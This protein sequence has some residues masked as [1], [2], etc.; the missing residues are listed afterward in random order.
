MSPVAQ[1]EPS[2]VF[3]PA[4][5]DAP[6]PAR[7]SRWRTALLIVLLLAV[8][9][10]SAWRF[11]VRWPSQLSPPVPLTIPPRSVVVAPSESISAAIQRVASGGEVIVEP[12]VYRETLRL[13]SNVR[14]RSRIARAASVRLSGGASE[15]DAA[16]VAAE[17]EGAEVS[18]LQI[19]GDSATPLGVGVFVRNATVL[20]SDLEI[21]GAH[22][23]A[24]EIAAGSGATVLG[25]YVHDNPGAGLTV[26]ATAAPRIA[27]SQFIRNGM[28]ERAAGAI[29]IDAGARPHLDRNVFHGV[30]AE[31]LTGLTQAERAAARATNWF[32]PPDE[33]SGRRSGGSGARGRR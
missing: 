17:V 4:A 22:V 9:A 10:Y 24:I 6:A 3:L 14:V 33:G 30:L 2:P 20:L 5:G 15:S 29:V 32:M 19:V 31:S 8:A 13:R 27:H 21:S 26:R 28:S 7:G 11:G 25:A 18:G 23:A 1:L 16:I 12:G